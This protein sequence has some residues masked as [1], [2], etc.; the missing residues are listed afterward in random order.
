MK[1]E[2]HYKKFNVIKRQ[3]NKCT[4]YYQGQDKDKKLLKN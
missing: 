2:H 3:D 4:I 1:D